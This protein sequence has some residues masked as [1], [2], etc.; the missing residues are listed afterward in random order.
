MSRLRPVHSCRSTW[1]NGSRRAP[2]LL[3]VRR[4]PLA[5]ART[6]PC[7]RVSTVTIRSAS[8]SFWG[9]R[10]TPSSR[11]SDF[12]VVVMSV[13]QPVELLRVVL[14]LAEDGDVQVQVPPGAEQ[15]LETGAGLGADRL[16]HLATAAEQHRFLGGALDVQQRVHLDQLVPLALG[17][18][19]PDQLLDGHRQGVRDLL[20]HLL[21]GRLADQ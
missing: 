11:Y 15:L 12:G 8:P 16:D 13:A 20:A 18:R 10:T 17:V 9:R 6:L 7:R 3:F 5:T 4:T 2:N 14:P 21:Q 1:L 19:T